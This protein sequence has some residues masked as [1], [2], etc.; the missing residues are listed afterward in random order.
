[1]INR[2]KRKPDGKADHGIVIAEEPFFSVAEGTV[3]STLALPLVEN[4]LTAQTLFS[5]TLVFVPS[6]EALIRLFAEHRLL[7]L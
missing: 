6:I 3:T 5:F 4:P 1:M 2:L 7:E